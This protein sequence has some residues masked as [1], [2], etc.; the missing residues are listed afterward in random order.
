MSTTATSAVAS[1]QGYAAYERIYGHP[2]GPY[3]VGV[4][5]TQFTDVNRVDPGDTT[6]NRSLQTEI[7]YP[8][9]VNENESKERNKFSDFVG[10]KGILDAQEQS[11][12][13]TLANKAFGGYRDGLTI[14][15]LDESVWVNRAVRDAKPLSEKLPFPL[16]VFSHGSGA[17][18]ASYIYWCEYLASH[19]YVV[20]ACDHPGS[21][22][23]T[24]VDGQPIVPDNASPRSKRSSMEHERPLDIQTIIDGMQHLCR[25]DSRFQGNVDCQMVGVTGMSFGGYTVAEYLERHDPR[26]KAAILQCP[27]IA[28]SG[29]K[30][31]ETDR[32][33][34]QTPVMVMLGSE[35]T[36]IGERGNQA[37]RDYVDNHKDG[38]SYLLEIL[39]GGHVSFT[40]CDI[41]DENY[42]NGIGA[43]KECPSLSQPGKTYLPLDI[44]EQHKMINSYGLA[45][46][47]AYLKGKED[48]KRYLQ[49][50]HF[51]ETGELIYRKG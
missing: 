49:E 45:F 10:L 3:A 29:S 6:R 7:W 27:S 37:G 35:D 17:Y 24:V 30:P 13:L 4:T 51:E 31:L 43:T 8:C 34:T 21:A 38:D 19:G 16:I 14:K 11:R 25:T 47:N 46:L 26:V 12:A 2:P 40:S 44:T 28:T 33:N 5:T 48:D 50:N 41:Y 36:V 18:R 20:A 15:E 39:R 1:T 32:T 42:G 9:F 22:R 23:F